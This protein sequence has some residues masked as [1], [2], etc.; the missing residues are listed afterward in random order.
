M[1]RNHKIGISQLEVLIALAIMGMMA[2][3]LANALSFS[4]QQLGRIRPVSQSVENYLARGI[5]RQWAEDMPLKR[6]LSPLSPALEGSESEVSF[7]TLVHDGY[8]WGGELT[9][10]LVRQDKE[11]IVVLAS[12]VADNNLNQ[13]QQKLTLSP[14]ANNLLISYYGRHSSEQILKWHSDWRRSN[15]LPLLVKIEWDSIDGPPAPPL[16]FQPANYDHAR[17]ISLSDVVPKL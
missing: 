5:L 9:T 8:F 15:S 16:T 1:R 17:S 11:Q 14:S 6:G 13:V 10:V 3:I 12:G 4:S 2:V 7:E